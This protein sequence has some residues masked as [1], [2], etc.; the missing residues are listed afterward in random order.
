MV[1]LKYKNTFITAIIL[2]ILIVIII[3]GVSYSRYKN[4][5]SI[6]KVDNTL[7]CNQK[8]KLK[9]TYEVPNTLNIWDIIS[10]SQLLIEEDNKLKLYDLNTN[11]SNKELVN[12]SKGHSVVNAKA[13]HD[14]LIWIECNENDRKNNKIFI[15]YFEDNSV[16]E[17]D[18]SNSDIIPSIS[19]SSRYI[20]YYI[21]DNKDN[22]N[23][24]LFDLKDK[25]SKVISTYKLNNEGNKIY[26]SAPNTDN[27]QV[28]W[29]GTINDK[30]TVYSY[31]I[32]SDIK[33]VLSKDNIVSNPVVKD[34]RIFAIQKNDFFDS[35]LNC[36]YASD[37]I[38]KYNV[39]NDTWN[40]FE[41]G[42]INNYIETPM[43]SVIKLLDDEGPLSWV[44]TFF[45]KNVYDIKNSE[46]ISVEKE[47][48]DLITNIQL[49]KNN[50]IYY[51]TSDYEDKKSSLIYIIPSE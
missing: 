42:R 39:E 25:S 14:G 19:V 16:N 21:V 22:I 44:S 4:N 36:D 34:N 12:I 13:F 29:S 27:K 7:S 3:A 11:K 2:L 48:A 32:E 49:V 33:R 43:E 47:G 8:E 37:F 45:V 26:I 10:E 6:S 5:N 28:V 17:L 31:S 50:V 46:F 23:I 38:V 1:K 35:E 41:E 9:Y 24:K 18:V 51:T 30:S 20:T 15:K 40:R